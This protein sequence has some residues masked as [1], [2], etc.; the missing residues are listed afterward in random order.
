MQ[1][2]HGISPSLPASAS[3]AATPS[4]QLLHDVIVQTPPRQARADGIAI[5]TFD[6][7]AAD[8]AVLVSIPALGLSRIVARSISPLDPAQVGQALALG[9][10]AGDPQRPIVLGVMLSA[11]VCAPAVTDVLV[12]GERV[13]LSAEH[14]IELRCGEAAIVLSAD[15]RIQLRGTY[16]TSQASATQ[17]ILGGSV[18]VN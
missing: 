16:I 2:P 7:I 4:E 12:D 11:P 6:G 3:A 1:Q 9:F 15:G 17:R 10:E 8:G 18:N 5:G 14:E 13:V